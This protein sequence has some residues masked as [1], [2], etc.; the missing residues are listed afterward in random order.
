MR[1]LKES[2]Y[3]RDNTFCRLNDKRIEIQ[4]RGHAQLTEDKETK[5]GEFIFFHPTED[6]AELL[7]LNSDKLDTYRLFAGSNSLCSKSLGFQ[8]GKDRLAVLFL[9]ENSPFTDKLSIQYFDLKTARPL[10]ALETEYLV[11]KAEATPEGFSFRLVGERHGL[12]MG[13]VEIATRPFTYQDRDFDVWMIHKAS[14]IEYSGTLSYQ[15]SPWKKFFK[16]EN[17]FLIATGWDAK[18][19]TFRKTHLYLAVNHKEKIQCIYVGTEKMK[20]KP[21]EPGWRCR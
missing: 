19:K 20:F 4:V 17:D 1:S 8:I 6:S 13:K 2:S 18:N 10:K 14:G 11:D 16:D 21:N 3:T 9:R 7:P 12:E 5:Y 15:K